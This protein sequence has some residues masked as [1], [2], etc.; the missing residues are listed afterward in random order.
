MNKINI[1]KKIAAIADRLDEKGLTELADE[2][3]G[4]SKDI[5]S[6]TEDEDFEIRDPNI[7]EYAFSDGDQSLDRMYRDVSKIKDSFLEYA[8]NNGMANEDFDKNEVMCSVVV[9]GDPLYDFAVE[10]GFVIAIGCEI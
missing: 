2:M 5:Y 8:K 6:D 9:E 7:S 3:D 10:N 1:I 4:I